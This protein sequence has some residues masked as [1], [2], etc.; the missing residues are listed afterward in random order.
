[1]KWQEK[2]SSFSQGFFETAC[3][4]PKLWQEQKKGDHG[5]QKGDIT[6]SH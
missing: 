1:M 5:V 4:R 2:G 3:T 6:P